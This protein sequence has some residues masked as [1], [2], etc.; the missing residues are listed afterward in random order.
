MTAIPPTRHAYYHAGRRLKSGH[1]ILGVCLVALPWVVFLVG[2]WHLFLY[3]SLGFMA[4]LVALSQR[5]LR[6][7]MRD[8]M[9]AYPAMQREIRVKRKNL[10]SA[11]SQSSNFQLTLCELEIVSG[12]V[13]G[14]SNKEIAQYLKIGESTVQYRLD[15]VFQK[16]GLSTRPELALFAEKHA[17]PLKKMGKD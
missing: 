9:T 4:M 8:W 11:T 3:L 6:R 7:R 15:R 14:Y 16:L 2:G 10:G 13:A 5:E 12:V 17:L 1:V